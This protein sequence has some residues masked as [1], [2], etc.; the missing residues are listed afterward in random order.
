M[1]RLQRHVGERDALINAIDVVA[2]GAGGEVPHHAHRASD[3]H[4][5]GIRDIQLKKN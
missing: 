3:F 1:H 4:G 5:L 2:D